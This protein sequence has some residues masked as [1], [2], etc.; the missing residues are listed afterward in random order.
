[1]VLINDISE[2]APLAAAGAAFICYY[3]S[4]D[5]IGLLFVYGR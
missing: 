5:L 1:M 2:A 3:F 4:A